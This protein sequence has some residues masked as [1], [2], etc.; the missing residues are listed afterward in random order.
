V[1]VG[2]VVAVD[3]GADVGAGVANEPT[4]VEVLVGTK[5]PALPA[6]VTRAEIALGSMAVLLPEQAA[7]RTANPTTIETGRANVRT[8]EDRGLHRQT[9]TLSGIAGNTTAGRRRCRQM[10]PQSGIDLRPRARP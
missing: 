3:D 8:V 10:S 6:G 9:R 2:A 1:T 4:G 5:V 7:I